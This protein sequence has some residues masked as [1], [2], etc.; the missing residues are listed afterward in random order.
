MT[1]SPVGFTVPEGQAAT[2]PPEERGLRRDE[3]RL[4]VASPG[5]VTHTTFRHLG[6]FLSPG[7]VVVVNASAT[8][9]AAIDGT[10]RGRPVVVHFSNRLSSGRWIIELR[11]VDGRGP[12]LEAEAGEG[13]SLDGEAF[14]LLE[15]PFTRRDD[16]V[17][18]WRAR[19]SAPVAVERHL[20]HHGRPIT[21]GYV[22][23]PWPLAAYQTVFA[24]PDDPSGASA[25]MPSA[26][27]PF[28]THLVA[29]LVSSGVLVV[30]VTLHA[31]V[32]SP[33]RNE[34]PPAEPYRVP[35]ATAEAVNSARRRG[36]RVVAVGTTVTRALESA[37]DRGGDVQPTEGWT[38]LVLSAERPAR[39]VNGLVTGWHP[40]EAS[41]LLL[42]EAVAGTDLV[43]QAYEAAAGADY[44]WHEFGDSCLLLPQSAP[45]AYHTRRFLWI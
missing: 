16:G 44:L 23:R 11:R 34:P 13:V 9:P 8:R 42:L 1:V 26:A 43:R 19:V 35:R 37:V 14:A 24:R 36:N 2:A 25:E 15:A 5:E 7:D 41:H 40:P 45:A 4:L 20:H 12:L 28:T 31:G 6:E 18:L 3:V 30:P 17:R 32:S 38:D 39:V 29:S 27:R 22:E 33:E 21:Y 10:W